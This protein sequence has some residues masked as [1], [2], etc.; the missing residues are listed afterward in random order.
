MSARIVNTIAEAIDDGPDPV[1]QV[2]ELSQTILDALRVN[3]FEVVELP[4]VA[5]PDETGSYRVPV[6]NL[7]LWE[8]ELLHDAGWEY[9]FIPEARQ[10]R[11]ALAAALA[12]LAEVRAE[13][14][15]DGDYG[16]QTECVACGT[17]WPCTTS[18]ILDRSTP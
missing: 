7:K 1:T 17:Q 6:D 9:A 2:T 13:H 15:P 4:K 10:L 18:A 8:I 12:T 3:G 16:Y 14:Q 11:A 5:G